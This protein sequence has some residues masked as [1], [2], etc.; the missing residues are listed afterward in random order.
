MHFDGPVRERF[1]NEF[2]KLIYN[3]TEPLLFGDF[4]KKIAVMLIGLLGLAVVGCAFMGPGF[5]AGDMLAGKG[6]MQGPLRAN[7]TLT[8]KAVLLQAN[9]EGD[10]DAALA[11][12]QKYGFEGTLDKTMFDARAKIN[13]AILAKDWETAAQL[14]DSL[15]EKMHEEM[16]ATR[17]R[18]KFNMNQ[19]L[20]SGGR[21]IGKWLAAGSNVSADMPDDEMPSNCP[22]ARGR[23]FGR[24]AN[25]TNAIGSQ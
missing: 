8:D 7:M 6:H 18:M 24:F 15:Q 14:H 11:V 3:Q 2:G 22:H 4:M 17:G 13:K 21:G 1:G 16:H 5:G 10:Y 20:A 25:Q 12:L 19:I 9:H 23:G